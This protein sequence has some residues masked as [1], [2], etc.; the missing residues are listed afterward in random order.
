MKTIF[1]LLLATVFTSAFAMNEGRITI[2]VPSKN[3]QVYVDGRVYQENDNSFVLNGVQPGNHTI[4]VYRIGNGNS[5]GQNGNGYGK[6]SRKNNNRNS[7]DLIYSSTV[8]V[9]PSYHVDIM[10]NRF[11][12]ALV[13]ERALNSRDGNWDDDDYNDGYDN[14]GYENGGYNNGGYNNGYQP[15]SDYDFQASLQ[16]I[17]SQWIGK[18]STARD[19]VNDN[20][21]SV[22][23]VKQVVQIF[24]S[25]NDKLELAKLSYRNLVDRQNFRQLYDQFSYQSQ[26]ELDRYVR[27]SRF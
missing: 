25:E 3:V 21:L 5:Y 7:N 26:A 17:R 19:L 9:R 20:H 16:K 6:N 18:M 11:G 8:Y 15:M 4:K 24:S 10:I 1:T 22:Y 27:D 13:D 14:D 2:T 23:Q 12:K